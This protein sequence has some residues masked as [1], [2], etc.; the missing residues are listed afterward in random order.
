MR[1]NLNNKSKCK[2]STVQVIR[3]IQEYNVGRDPERLQLKY[4][5]MRI[6]PFG[7]LRATSHI[8]YG[9]WA[10]GQV[11]KSAP[12]TWVCGDL[13]VENFGSYKG[14]NR[15][16]YFDI[17]D[18][19]EAALVP[20]SW[21]LVRMLTSL[22]VAGE[23][24]SISQSEA[25]ALCSVFLNSYASSLASGKA[26]WIETET[27]PGIIKD[28]L[29]GL[30]DR[31]RS[32]FLATRTVLKGKTRTFKVDGKRALPV[33][34]AQRTSVMNVMARFA[35]TQAE[36]DF[37]R[38]L[39]VARRIAGTG[40][41]GID[42][43]SILVN[44]KGTTKG[45]YLLDLKQSR[46]SSVAPYFDALQPKWRS[47]AHR[48]VEIQQRMQAVSV[49]LLQPVHF[50]DST[51]VLRELQPLE[52][53]VVL[54]RSYQTRG[55]LKIVIET[56]GRMLAWAQLRSAGRANSAIADELIDFGNRTK[57]REKLLAASRDM[58]TQV[59][60]DALA[61]N[62]AYDSGAFEV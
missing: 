60:K 54:N 42:R 20:S 22:Y 14:N 52:D 10:T 27:A 17:N 55:E 12:L 16:A 51:Y 53:R 5:K 8:F 30:K 37:F 21:E 57:W 6:T 43:F 29:V 44:G 56:M 1:Q 28:L 15:L 32:Q 13:H 59:R 24:L 45:H 31:Q 25:G 38:V 49:A 36:P 48:I 39:D 34:A 4:Q 47:E 35:K 7:F 26:Y 40:S 11:V 50:G 3:E 18:F 2:G 33:T 19:D 62:A 41:L 61:F 9:R 23:G 46:A 58:S